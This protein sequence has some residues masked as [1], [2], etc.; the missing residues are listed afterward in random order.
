MTRMR[1]KK[2]KRKITLEEDKVE[3]ELRRKRV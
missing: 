2:P 1:M 3:M